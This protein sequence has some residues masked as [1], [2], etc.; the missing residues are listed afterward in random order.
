MSRSEL[1]PFDP[2]STVMRQVIGQTLSAAYGFDDIRPVHW[3]IA[4]KIST[5]LKA[6]GYP[7]RPPRPTRQDKT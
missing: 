3:T 6:A 5:A 4:G 1:R 7:A 2:D